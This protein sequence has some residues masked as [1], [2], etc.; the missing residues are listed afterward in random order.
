MTKSPAAASNMSSPTSSTTIEPKT[1][2]YQRPCGCG[3]FI[4]VPN[5][6]HGRQMA[7]MRQLKR[8]DPEA[9]YKQLEEEHRK[10]LPNMPEP[11]VQ[12][13]LAKFR[14]RWEKNLERDRATI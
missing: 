3:N 4:Y 10:V 2:V 11:M 7:E 12:T 1:L 13:Y 14:E 8:I 5:T 6:E 9:A